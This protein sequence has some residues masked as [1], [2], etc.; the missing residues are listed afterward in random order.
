MSNNIQRN[1]WVLDTPVDGV[2]VW[3]GVGNSIPII[4]GVLQLEFVNYTVDNSH[5][6]F[7]D[8]DGI[9]V[10]VLDGASDLRSV[11]TGNIGTLRRGLCFQATGT[12]LNGGQVLVYIK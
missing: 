1:P 7:R 10:A 11:R 4:P 5:V 2:N 12:I 3:M 6:V 8:L 9:L